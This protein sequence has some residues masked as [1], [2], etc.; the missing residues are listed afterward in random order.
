MPYKKVSKWEECQSMLHELQEADFKRHLLGEVTSHILPWMEY[1][2][3]QHRLFPLV[4]KTACALADLGQPVLM[5]DT[6]KFSCYILYL[7]V[8]SLSSRTQR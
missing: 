4:Y 1:I 8:N 5:K 7:E 3:P 6:S 2:G